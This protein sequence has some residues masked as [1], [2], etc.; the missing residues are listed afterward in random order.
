MLVLIVNQE[1]VQTKIVRAFLLD[2]ANSSCWGHFYLKSF[3]NS[4]MHMSKYV[5]LRR[6]IKLKITK[7]QCLS[8][9]DLKNTGTLLC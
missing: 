3:E 8:Q 2:T 6:N 7:W 4:L 5:A 1:N 9:K